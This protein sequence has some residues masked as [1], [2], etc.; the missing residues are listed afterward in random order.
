MAESA[1]KIEK[2]YPQTCITLHICRVNPTFGTKY[3][4]T[5]PCNEGLTRFTWKMESTSAIYSFFWTEE[6]LLLGGGEMGGFYKE[7]LVTTVGFVF[8]II[9]KIKMIKKI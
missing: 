5:L 7:A 2:I 1:H 3:A 8:H 6:S 4:T 9:I